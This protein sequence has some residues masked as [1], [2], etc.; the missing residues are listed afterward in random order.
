MP[1]SLKQAKLI[2][3]RVG[4]RIVEES[5][6]YEVTIAGRALRDPVSNETS[7]MVFYASSPV[8]AAHTALVQTGIHAKAV[9]ELSK[10]IYVEEDLLFAS[11]D[12]QP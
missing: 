11:E 7:P 3:G 1:M 4:A 2:A 6:S 8:Q 5:A 9:L 10:R 12:K